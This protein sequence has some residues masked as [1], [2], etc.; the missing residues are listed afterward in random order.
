MRVAPTDICLAR[1]PPPIVEGQ[2]CPPT[3]PPTKG[4]RVGCAYIPLRPSDTIREDAFLP[5]QGGV[6]LSR[7]YRGVFGTCLYSSW[8]LGVMGN[9]CRFLRSRSRA[10]HAWFKEF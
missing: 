3:R 8:V 9:R 10:L 2:L 6:D 7:C 4:T 5:D 1:C